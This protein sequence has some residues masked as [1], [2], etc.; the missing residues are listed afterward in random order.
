[1][2]KIN[3]VLKNGTVNVDTEIPDLDALDLPAIF[4]CTNEE[5]KHYLDDRNFIGQVMKRW[6]QEAVDT[7]QTI[8]LSATERQEA[9]VAY[10]LPANATDEQINLSVAKGTNFSNY[11]LRRISDDR[12]QSQF[13]RALAKSFPTLIGADLVRVT[14]INEEHYLFALNMDLGDIS[15]LIARLMTIAYTDQPVVTEPVASESEEEDLSWLKDVL[16]PDEAKKLYKVAYDGKG[17]FHWEG[18]TYVPEDFNDLNLDNLPEKISNT[19]FARLY[20]YSRRTKVK[21]IEETSPADLVGA[22]Q[23][24]VHKE[25]GQ[26]RTAKTARSRKQ[27]SIPEPPP[28]VQK[29]IDTGYFAQEPISPTQVLTYRPAADRAIVL[30]NQDDPFTDD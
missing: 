24:P 7:A 1:M 15:I 9:I 4:L 19:F 8:N 25:V 22:L 21:K 12:F 30:S 17:E 23:N 14:P 3:I 28:F 18:K 13:A 20:S 26:S 29:A 6:E 2:R 16:P 11:L 10:G 5:Y 27:A